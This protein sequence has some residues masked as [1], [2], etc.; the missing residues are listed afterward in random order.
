MLPQLEVYLL[1]NDNVREF[2]LN[3]PPVAIQTPDIL[4][5]GS[6]ILPL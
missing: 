5:P 3:F 2:K 6:K 4:S 1:V